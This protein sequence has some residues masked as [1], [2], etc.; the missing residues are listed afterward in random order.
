M[1]SVYCDHKSSKGEGMG[2]VGQIERKTQERVVMLFCDYLHYEY[3]GNWEY[4]ENN[5]NIER[6]LLSLWLEGGGHNSNGINKALRELD[7]AAAL[8]GGNNLYDANKAVYSLLRYG[9][10]VKEGAGEQFQTV[11]LIDWQNPEKNHF[12]LAEEVTIKGALKKRPDLV[13]YVNGIALGV[14]ELKRASVGGGKAS[15]RISITRR[16]I[17]SVTSLPPCSWLWPGMIPRGFVTVL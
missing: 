16:R 8:G 3:L 9:V 1:L 6:E 17:L 7:R 15:A 2:K 14:I 4:R 13:L 10:K 11:F 12:G 5:R